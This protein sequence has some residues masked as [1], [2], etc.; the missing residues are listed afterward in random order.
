MM[1]IYNFFRILMYLILL[2]CNCNS[3]GGFASYSTISHISLSAC[4]PLSGSD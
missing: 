4:V 2:V 3:T 1:T